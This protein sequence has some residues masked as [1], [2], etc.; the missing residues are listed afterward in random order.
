MPKKKEPQKKIDWTKTPDT[1]QKILTEI[2]H[3][4][5]THYLFYKKKSPQKVEWICSSC[6]AHQIARP[7]NKRTRMAGERDFVDTIVDKDTVTCPCCGTPLVCKPT[8]RVRER[9]KE[10]LYIAVLIK[11]R[12]AIYINVHSMY[13]CYGNT[14]YFSVEGHT[15]YT[16]YKYKLDFKNHKTFCAEASYW[17]PY[18]KPTYITL[19][20]IAEPYAGG[21]QGVR[22]AI[23]NIEEVDG[24]PL[25]YCKPNTV[26]GLDRKIKFLGMLNEFPNLERM[27]KLG[28]SSDVKQIVDYSEPF[29]RTIDFDGKTPWA[30][31]RLSKEEYDMLG[32]GTIYRVKEYHKAKKKHPK[33][34]AKDI[35]T[36]MEFERSEPYSETKKFSYE[37]AL[38]F[39]S[40]HKFVKYLDSQAK[41]Y[42]P[43]HPCSGKQS[44]GLVYRTYADYISDCVKLKMP[45]D[46]K[47]IALPKNLNEAHKRTT[48][49]IN[50][51]L[52]EEREKEQAR[53]RKERC[54][55]A[56]KIDG[57]G[58]TYHKRYKKL[59]KEY[60]FEDEE[61]FIKVPTGAMEIIDEGIC[62]GHCVGGYAKRH[63]EGKTTILF[64][65]KKSAPDEPLYTIEVSDSP[66]SVI[67]IRAH[68]N[69]P[70]TEGQAFWAE[71]VKEMQSKYIKKLEKPKT[72]KSKVSA[73]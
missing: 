60:K 44:A 40:V 45:L 33:C 28:M 18:D 24:T 11:R 65:R 54:N 7:E 5:F 26:C 10:S 25:A 8:G 56:K 12:N 48:D 15:I 37:V 6:G 62:M 32:G 58:T 61:Y 64:M 35:V 3:E 21:C 41:P 55:E 72:K 73:A 17:S 27:V 71:F 69:G 57:D 19:N 68:G 63:I 31:L 53:L 52:A 70:V 4:Q 66:F 36:I 38:N 34:S 20:R 1:P 46:D 51:I 49:A 39:L 47:Q 29:K 30:M 43:Y 59:C 16:D 50:A 9:L 14:G 22:T 67:Q 2:C 42:N 13:C 23:Y